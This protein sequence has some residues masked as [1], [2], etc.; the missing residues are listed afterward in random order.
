M[1]RIPMLTSLRI[2]RSFITASMLVIQG[3]FDSTFSLTFLFILPKFYTTM[4]YRY[5]LTYS[6]FYKGDLLKTRY[7]RK[8]GCNFLNV[9][10]GFVDFSM[11]PS[12][13]T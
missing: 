2:E 12:T 3:I 9:S 11:K 8:T 7:G 4:W 6:V 10:K 13:L 1:V 5:Y